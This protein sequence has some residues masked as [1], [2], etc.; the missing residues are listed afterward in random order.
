MMNRKFLFLYFF[1]ISPSLIIV[2][3]ER[4][5]FFIISFSSNDKTCFLFRKIIDISIDRLLIMQ[6]ILA[7]VLN[8][9]LKE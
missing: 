7:K 5:A 3:N 2:K 8:L 9:N 1:K 6:I 4:E